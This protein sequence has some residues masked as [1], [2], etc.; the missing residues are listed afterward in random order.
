MM[1]PR[2]VPTGSKEEKNLTAV[3]KM[4]EAISPNDYRYEVEITY[5]DFGQQW[6]WTTIIAHNDENGDHW[7]AINPME[8]E[9]VVTAETLSDLAVIAEH[10]TKGKYWLD[11]PNEAKATGVKVTEATWEESLNKICN[12][13][14]CDACPFKYEVDCGDLTYTENGAKAIEA[15]FKNNK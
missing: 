12:M 7:Q 11:R 3:A 4:L 15:F 10:I 9:H 2:T 5:F 8:W 13:T 14:E 1:N 6:T